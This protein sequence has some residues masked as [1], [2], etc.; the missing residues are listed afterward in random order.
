MIPE[1]VVDEVRVR[2]DVVDIIGQHVQLK[3]AGKQFVGLCP[4]HHEKTPS[5]Y[6]T[7]AKNFYKC[8][9]CGEAGD[10]FTFLMKRDG[11]S[12]QDA[13]RHV[14]G[15]VG[16]DVPEQDVRPEDDP[17]RALY[18]AIAFAADFYQ[19]QLWNSTTGERARVY[20]EKRELSR[21]MA[22][23]FGVGYAP[24]SWQGLRDAARRH[25][26]SDDVLLGA[27]LVKESE[28]SD[29]PYDRLRD[30][31]IFPIADLS[32]RWIGFGGRVIGRAQDNVPKYLNSPETAIYHKGKTLYGLNWSRNAIRR[33]RAAL[34]VEGYMDYVSLVARGVDNVV[35]G[36]GTAL[37]QEQ[38][39]LLARYTKQALLLYDSDLAGL[40]ATFRTG[41]ELLSAGIE[42]LVVTLPEGEDP[43]SVVRTGGSNALNV[44][45]A[46]AV[47][48][49][50]R[51]LQILEERKF[52]EDIEGVRRALDR[53]LP[54]LRAA[55]DPALKDIYVD[56]VAKRTGVRRETLEA[57]LTSDRPV[58]RGVEQ[59]R[60]QRRSADRAPAPNNDPLRSEE[61]LLLLLMLRDP[62]R[63]EQTSAVVSADELDTPEYR[64]LFEALI[65]RGALPRDPG[66]EFALS[67]QA[68]KILDELWRDPQEIIHG[69]ETFD[70][71]VIQIKRAD[72][73]TR[74][75]QLRH[76]QRKAAAEEAAL[77]DRQLAELQVQLRALDR[78]PH[79]SYKGSSRFIRN[80]A[81]SQPEMQ[82]GQ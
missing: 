6:V 69:D 41:D 9:G 15:R 20:L 22:E 50:D 58:A 24:A 18:E 10:A 8:F 43:D 66:Q 51:K 11:L 1:R 81:L 53:L 59:R 36:L 14:A 60:Y 70:A 28:R 7:P 68:R 33:E 4:F 72:L 38:A 26:I 35:A 45:L 23:R 52:F 78:N 74:R 80:P 19:E 39:Q 5:F 67:P 25:G 37:T 29:E 61:R 64:E 46:K 30:R 56:R 71:C 21:E 55:A 77:I 47:D 34:L 40:K 63:I 82:N 27:G 65:E 32:G 31:L 12:F 48:V 62:A 16:V 2:A 75:S 49:L 54:T 79:R 13:V 44:H 76:R 73:L 57:E 3:R 42:P 17:H